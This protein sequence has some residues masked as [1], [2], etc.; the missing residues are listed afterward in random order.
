V[1]E[2]FKRRVLEEKTGRYRKIER[3]EKI[4]RSGEKIERS[5]ID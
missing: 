1:G 2:G 3:R 5:G 4:E